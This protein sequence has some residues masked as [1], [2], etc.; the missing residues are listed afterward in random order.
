[1]T[2]M[3]KTSSLFNSSNSIFSMI[4][5]CNENNLSEVLRFFHD[6]LCLKEFHEVNALN[7][8]KTKRYTTFKYCWDRCTKKD[9]SKTKKK[10]THKTKRENGLESCF[11]CSILF[12]DIMISLHFSGDEG[13]RLRHTQLTFSK[14]YFHKN[15]H[16]MLFYVLVFSVGGRMWIPGLNRRIFWAQTNLLIPITS[17]IYEQF[18]LSPRMTKFIPPLTLKYG[19]F[20]YAN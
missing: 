2:Q 3:R 8:W 11:K 6:T 13:Y 7:F 9:T 17:F 4:I 10:T 15:G 12:I 14:A 18:T 19:R 5:L 16:M 20:C 1:M